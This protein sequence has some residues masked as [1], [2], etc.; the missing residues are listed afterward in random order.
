MQFWNRGEPKDVT[1][2]PMAMTNHVAFHL[3]RGRDCLGAIQKRLANKNANVILYSLTV[4]QENV[5]RITDGLK[6]DNF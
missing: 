5:D 4:G 3:G 6:V 2:Q 1:Q